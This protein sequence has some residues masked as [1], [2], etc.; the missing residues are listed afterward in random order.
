M[1]DGMEIIEH[2]QQ[3]G[4]MRAQPMQQLAT[5]PMELLSMVTQRGASIEEISKFMDL[6]ERQQANEARQA[7]VRAM[8]EFK[9]NAPS[10]YKDKNVSFSG[11]N[12]NHAT[13][14]AICEAVIGLLAEN[15]I[16]HDWDT[17]QPDSGMIKVTCTLTHNMGYS[18]STSMESP[19]DNSGK[20]NAIQQIA[21]TITYLQRYT[22]LGSCGL[23]AKEAD[24]DGR[25]A[26]PERE[27][28][29]VQKSTIN[30]KRFDNAIAAVKNDGYLPADVR[31]NF[32]LTPDQE[33][34]LADAEKELAAA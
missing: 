32:L 34:V 9:K 25:S 14:G 11:T 26:A 12:Y 1:S 29:P 15:G 27:A 23:A 20:K 17:E 19:P 10:I 8:A 22:L 3:A 24:D 5:T 28:K 21:S 4:A 13:L 33:T 6:M 7:Y 18:K 30:G 31:K 2:Q 16:S